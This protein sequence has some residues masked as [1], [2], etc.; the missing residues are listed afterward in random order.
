MAVITG[1][2][3]VNDNLTGGIGDDSISGLGGNDTLDGGGGGVD[4]LYGGLGDDLLYTRADD[5]AYGGD[6]NDI[7]AVYGDGQATMDGG[8]GTGD[9]LRFEGGY[10]ITGAVLTGLEQLN[11]S[12][13]Y[14]TT[15]Q[16]ASFG[17]VSGYG[18]TYTS[19]SVALTQ[20]G[21]ASITL[22]STLTSSFSI[23]G[24]SQAENLTF[25]PG[26][27]HTI[28]AYMGGGNDKVVAA[29]GNDSLRG[30]DG[31]DTL[32]GLDGDDSIDG[33]FGVDQLNGGNGNDYLITSSFDSAYGGANNDLISI[34]GNAPAVLN[35]GIG[36]DTLR[37]ENTFDISG[38]VLT[39]IEQ[40]NLYG[41]DSMT[42]TQ[43]GL[44]TTVTSYAVGYTTGTV[45]LT[46]GGTASVALGA[47]MSASFTITGSG[48][49]DILTFAAGY[50]GSIVSYAGGGNDKTVSSSGNDSLRGDDGNDTLLGGASN[51]SLDGGTGIDS[52]DGGIGND[53]LIA[54]LH[55]NVYG[56]GNDDLVSVG[57]SL[58][59]IL[60]GGLGQDTLR[61]EGAFDISGATISGFEQLNL[62]G[63]DSL[64]AAQLDTFALV[65]GYGVGYTTAG[66]TLTQGGT[67][68][69][70]VSSNLTSSFALTGSASADIL[71]FAPGYLGTIYAY[72][73]A[74]NDYVLSSSG[75]DS[76][77][78]EDGND[79]LLGFAGNDSIDGGGG[80]DS[81]AGGAGND[82]LIVR[83]FDSIYGGAD[84]DLLAVSENFPGV[85]DGGVAGQDTL[86][87]EGSFDIT[88]ATITGIEQLNLNGTDSMTAAQLDSFGTVAG[89]SAAYATATIVLTQGG[90]ADINVASTV[91]NYFSLTGS[92][93]ADILT[94][95]PGYLG[96]VYAYVGAGDDSVT[97]SSGNDSLRGEDGN[98]T[99]AGFDGNDSI[100]GGTGY[101]S[102]Y[103]GAGNDYLIARY[104][105]NLFGGDNDDLISVVE[106]LPAGLN[107][108]ALGQ[109]TL[110]FEG[111]YDISGAAVTGFEQLNVS[112]NDLMT[113]A[114]MA[115]FPV[116]SG[117]NT[118]TGTGQITL[119]A[120]GTATVTLASTLNNYFFLTGSAEAEN[121]TFNASYIAKI[122]AYMGS[123]ND[124][125]VSASG[126]DSL[127]GDEGNDS[128][129]GGAGNDSMDGGTGNDQLFGGLGDDTLDGFTGNDSLDGGAG[130]DFLT[131]RLGDSVYGGANDDLFSVTDNLPAVLSGGTGSDTLRFE[132]AYDISS[133][134]LTGFE[135][136]NLYS[137]VAMKTAQLASFTTVQG[138]GAGYTSATVRVTD[139]GAVALNLAVTLSSSFTFTGSNDANTVSFNTGYIGAIYVNAGYGNDNAAAASGAD[140]LRGEGGND[141]LFGLGG[142]DT[143]D[144]GIGADRLT[145]GD[146][147]DVMTGGS[148]KDVF[149]FVNVS[150]SAAALPDRITDFEASGPSQGDKIDLSVIDAD[151]GLGANNAFIFGAVGLGGVSLV[152]SGTDTL[153]R[154]NIDNDAAFESVILI[155]DGAVTASS[156]TAADF[157]L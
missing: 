31:N 131:V 24:S 3:N 52:I 82:V 28:F 1:F 12:S 37:F 103:G 54:R 89:Y 56:G 18:S 116:I 113:T 88:G 77:R 102:L 36:A 35:G 48:T 121:I 147:V 87:F 94:F 66:L 75:N 151:G 152:D 72:T 61:F 78:G 62:T 16:L 30:E 119:T 117:Y 138:Y 129:N 51:D 150:N 130:N 71:T 153:V 63:Q 140:S 148:G 47:A 107:G 109:D 10:D 13:G 70:S 86:R 141:T 33:G 23:T 156:Y 122:Y 101:D 19:A 128:I 99:L 144:G 145:G 59:N 5:E 20:G 76:L 11:I 40:L 123:G 2:N 83:Y 125:L 46:Q 69:I 45:V 8:V 27:A 14:M 146:G 93:D 44:F 85:L 155:A 67:A 21:A 74:G 50:L 79:T 42:A 137:A 34:T 110:R 143:L 57:E 127:R 49:A 43:L 15:A 65:S 39:G 106:N 92:A 84:D 124:V 118:A 135:N 60:S 4:S 95:A 80:M 17:L 53:Y 22:S 133:A 114:Q 25:A 136:L 149:V 26:Y 81:L 9:I 104:N 139:G 108:G 126:D 134:A 105:D 132:N 91:T 111:A 96:T 58:P 157:V 32:T 73:G 120:G 55:D 90:T 115:L 29:A 97:A 7:L 38:S 41:T 112:G 98:D 64:T 100:D 6:G 154:L 68:D 142:N